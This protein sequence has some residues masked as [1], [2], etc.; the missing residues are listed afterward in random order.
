MV[1][2]KQ[3]QLPGVGLRHDFRTKDGKLVGVISHRTGHSEIF[4][5]DADDP[6]TA[7]EIV[8]LDP[9]ERRALV[10]LLGGSRITQQLSRLTTEIEGLSIDWIDVPT[11]SPYDRRPLGDTQTRTRTGVS[12][13]AVLRNGTASPAPGPDV[14]LRTGDTLVVVGTAR[15]IQRLVELLHTG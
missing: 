12:I 6:D 13:V 14:E 1:E 5:C 11:A 8:D 3:T 15:G 2:I 9:D 7:R 4:V 10:E